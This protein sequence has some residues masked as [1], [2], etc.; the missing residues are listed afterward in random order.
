MDLS[1][2]CWSIVNKLHKTRVV[3]NGGARI[4]QRGLPAKCQSCR[5]SL[6]DKGSIGDFLRWGALQYFFRCCGG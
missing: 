4:R 2:R 5:N 1:P 3:S 6:A